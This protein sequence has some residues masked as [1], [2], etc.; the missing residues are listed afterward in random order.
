MTT[1]LALAGLLALLLFLTAYPL[2]MLVYGSLHTTPPG[3]AGTFN[4]DGYRAMLSRGNA[5]VLLNTVALSLVK[6]A[7]AMALAL[8]LAWIVARTDTPYR[9][10]LEVLITL[11]FYIPPIL[12]AMAWG[13]LATPKGGLI[14]LAWIGL[15]GSREPLV[16]IYSYGGVVWQSCASASS[17]A[18]ATSTRSRSAPTDSPWTPRP[19]RRSRRAPTSR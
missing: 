6:T 18:P 8:F 2:A 10:A 3:E 14:N 19:I 11:P 1:R 7:L 9:D 13:M 17:A 4:L 12:T 15:T 5:L 16:N